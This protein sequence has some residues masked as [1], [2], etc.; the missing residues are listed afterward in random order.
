MNI[1]G[2][3]IDLSNAGIDDIYLINQIWP[4]NVVSINLRYN[5]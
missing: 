2:I 4:E 3:N 1:I 5:K